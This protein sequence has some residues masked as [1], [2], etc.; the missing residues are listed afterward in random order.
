MKRVLLQISVVLVCAILGCNSQLRNACKINQFRCDDGSK[1]LPTE[2][3][4]NGKKDCPQGED[5]RGNDQWDC[6]KIVLSSPCHPQNEF[7]CRFG[8]CIKREQTCDGT[9]DCWG[10]TDESTDTC[11]GRPTQKPPPPPPPPPP[12]SR[13]PP[14]DSPPPVATQPKETTTRPRPQ[15]TRPRPRPPPPQP[16]EESPQS[17]PRPAPSPP[18]GGCSP[19]TE[20][21]QAGFDISCHNK[22]G[23]LLGNCTAAVP[24]GSTAT[25]KCARYYRL[26]GVGSSTTVRKCQDN[27]QWT[28][29]RSNFVCSL[30]CGIG[31]SDT[32]GLVTGGVS[33]KRGK[34]PWHAAL[35]HED[36]PNS[37]KWD[38]KCGGSLITPQAILTAAHCTT[39]KFTE[40][41]LPVHDIQ[42]G[43]GRFHRSFNRH[44]NGEQ[45]RRVRF[46][47]VHP[48]YNQ[49]TLESDIAL[50]FLDTPAIIDDYVRPVCFPDDDK[51]QDVHP[52]NPGHL[53]GWGRTSGGRFKDDLQE[54]T[55][56]VV[57]SHTCKA[58]HQT[59][60]SLV[61]STNFCAGYRNGTS[62]CDGDSGGGLV[63]LD[64]DSRR[65]FNVQGIVSA[66]VAK[67]T[68]GGGCEDKYYAVFTKVGKFH[69]WIESKLD[70][71]YQR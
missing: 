39:K 6:T 52:G 29:R 20:N 13:R 15:Q 38:L 58:A 51:V 8:G 49:N 70:T 25:Y 45:T 48:D 59:F 62:A 66:G 5:E 16:V 21:I 28:T 1:C 54:A 44:D 14:P 27:G 64:S 33:S 10:A 68:G 56:P 43:L 23:K 47:E 22:Y 37:G 65:H 61:R 17:Q 2:K 69:R 34:W 41:P 53:V 30:E 50:I 26:A 35:F 19:I 36:P 18:K 32:A 9:P 12:P 7:R 57:D 11:V 42:I 46:I 60:A 4:C 67:S 24:H 31:G 71:H 3:L 55:I 63:F 40:M